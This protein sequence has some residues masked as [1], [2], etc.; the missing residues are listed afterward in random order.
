MANGNQK[1]NSAT[2]DFEVEHWA[3]AALRP[4]FA[5]LFIPSTFRLQ[6]L[7]LSDWGGENLRQDVRWKFEMPPVNNATKNLFLEHAML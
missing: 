1:S 6:T 7:L 2:L 5:L 4:S 3:P